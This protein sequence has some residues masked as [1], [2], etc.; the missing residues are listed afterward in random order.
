MLLSYRFIRGGAL[1]AAAILSLSLSACGGKHEAAHEE[2]Q[3]DAAH[4]GDHAA[5]S[6]GEHAAEAK[7]A[8]HEK[9]AAG[10]DVSAKH[11][12][13]DKHGAA[14]KHGS[15]EKHGAAEGHGG[16]KHGAA[17]NTIGPDA[18]GLI[19]VDL[20]EFTITQRQEEKDMI[21][22]IRFQI[23]GVIDYEKRDKFEKLLGQR[24]QRVRDSVITIVQ[25]AEVE[26]LTDPSLGWLKS[27]MV[28]AMNKLLGAKLLKEVVFSDFAMLQN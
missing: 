21:L 6:H 17:K 3:G 4:A 24:R 1:V 5:D 13:G 15:A 22:M 11:G 14:A 8:G 26:H 18:A 16:G 12:S 19:E 20:G 9:A 7:E 25:G 10:H 2:D 28:P 23:F 27:E